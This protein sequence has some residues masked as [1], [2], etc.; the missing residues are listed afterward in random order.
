[1]SK[2]NKE[3]AI[4]GVIALII[5]ITYSILMSFQVTYW[6]QQNIAYEQY[7]Q[8]DLRQA[9]IYNS[10]FASSDEEFTKKIENYPEQDKT[11][12]KALYE[13]KPEV[14]K[15]K[16]ELK[17]AKINSEK[18]TEEL[19]T[20]HN[21]LADTAE[22][23]KFMNIKDYL[24]QNNINYKISLA[25]YVHLREIFVPKSYITSAD[26]KA[27]EDFF[28]AGIEFYG[29]SENSEDYRS[30]N[31]IEKELLSANEIIS[32]DESQLNEYIT[33]YSELIN[34][35][36]PTLEYQD[37]IITNGIKTAGDYLFTI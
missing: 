29:E 6:K 35:N 36:S 12:A 20:R 31:D 5:I 23:V 25:E 26:K 18:L 17:E 10:T 24:I 16:K 4:I 8:E 1:M 13:I 34:E 2:D 11:I 3:W 19:S 27:H 9:R 21:I 14:D 22:T 37:T 15:I 7:K 33:K 32:K 28:T 30:Y